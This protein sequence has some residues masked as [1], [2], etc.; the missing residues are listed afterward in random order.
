MPQGRGSQ[1]SSGYQSSPQK[2]EASLDK[3]Y[4]GVIKSVLDVQRMGRLK[5]WIPDLYGDPTDESHWFTVSYLSPFAG[6]TPI[7]DEKNT[8]INK[9]NG[10]LME[11]SQQSYGWWAVPPDVNNQV[12][13][14]F[15]GGNQARGFWFGCAYQ[16]YMN[17]MVPGI[18][19]NISNQGDTCGVNPPVVEYNA[20]SDGI[21]PPDPPR[22]RYEPLHGEAN[23][24]GL[25]QQG[26]Y[27][28]NERGPTTS[29]S[30]R[31]EISRVYGFKSPGGWSFYMDDIDSDEHMRIRGPKGT[32]FLVHDAG[33][34]I[35]LISKK[36]DS[37]FELSDE[38]IDGYTKHSISLRAEKDINLR[39]D[40]DFNIHVGRD[41]HTRI[42]RNFTEFVGGNHDNS[43]VGSYYRTTSGTVQT[44]TQ[45]VVIQRSG[46]RWYR[47][48][49][50][51]DDN[52]PGPFPQIAKTKSPTNK[53]DIPNSPPCYNPTQ[54]ST[55]VDRLITH[56]PFY[57]HPRSAKVPQKTDETPVRVGESDNG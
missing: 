2:G 50:R 34:Y 18:P 26:L 33:G 16:Q 14:F 35:Y 22:P 57:L 48:A 12:A 55:I 38:G 13:V 17:H 9:H 46:T 30:R 45:G 51:I 15:A 24:E 43:I 41:M 20:Y 56:E 36:G 7:M 49:P 47:D 52:L 29:G 6:A 28:D 1:I 31:D 44:Y 42:E 5:V 11:D 25:Y 4:I 23:A 19:Q 37:W 27:S 21:Q 53:Q 39:A 3:I 10:Q 40:R 8:I 54:L 32:Q